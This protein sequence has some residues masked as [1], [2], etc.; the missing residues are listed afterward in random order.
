MTCGVPV[1]FTLLVPITKN[2]LQAELMCC[3][4]EGFTSLTEPI[5]FCTIVELFP[6]NV[7]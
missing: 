2:D 7:R 5:I 1:I 4:F 3:V 6:S